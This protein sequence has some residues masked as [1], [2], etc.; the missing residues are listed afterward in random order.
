ML[1]ISLDGLQVLDA[2]DRRGSFAGAAAELHRVPSTISYTV[3]KLEQDLGIALF[4]R[5]GP[6]IHLT[7]AGT[8]L[9][10]EGR[11]LLKAAQDLEHR[12]RRVASGWETQFALGLESLL[13]PS[14]LAED[15]R[16]FYRVADHTRLRL[17]QDTLS[18]SWEALLDRRVDLIIA[19]AGDG[20]SGGGYITESMGSVPFVFAVA[21]E[22]PLATA[23]KPLDK[24]SLRAHRA[25]AVADS[26]RRLIPRTV[27]LLFGQDTLTVPDIFS[28]YAY[29]IA[30]FGFGYLP[31][32]YARSA[33]DA[34]QLVCKQVE[35]QRP[36]E[37]LHLA[38]RSGED[39]AALAWWIARMQRPGCLNQML[40]HTAR[41]HFSATAA[42]A[43]SAAPRKRTRRSG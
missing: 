2:V 6:R 8:E 24:A 36:D 34:G 25:I 14:A 9:L 3:A 37:E 7:A 33:I 20:P 12:V 28:K 17:S 30:G 16:A 26:A 21:P 43:A 18:G 15:I 13:P 35:E 31:E 32:V 4:E 39:G 42:P 23:K 22:H 10:K 5:A 19:A 40:E 27:G 29:Q 1:K 11:H 41:T 38:W